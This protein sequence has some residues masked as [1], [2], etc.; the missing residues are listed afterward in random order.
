MPWVICHTIRPC[1]TNW[2][3][4][5]FLLLRGSH[6]IPHTVSAHSQLALKESS[7]SQSSVSSDLDQLFTTSWSP[8]HVQAWRGSPFMYSTLCRYND[9]LKN[10]TLSSICDLS[11]IFVQRSSLQLVSALKHG[12]KKSQIVYSCLAAP[13]T[14]W[15]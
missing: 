4:C 12:E 2:P 14:Y 10:P 7:H 11:H 6:S 8:G 5:D 1:K 15:M 13:W 3:K 9:S